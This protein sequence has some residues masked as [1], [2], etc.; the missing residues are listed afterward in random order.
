[1]DVMRRGWTFGIGFAI[2]GVLTA[3]AVQGLDSVLLGAIV[4]FFAGK[5]VQSLLPTVRGPRSQ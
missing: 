3:V 2:L 1:M 4:C 5:A